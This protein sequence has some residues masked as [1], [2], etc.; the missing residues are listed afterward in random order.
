MVIEKHIDINDI[1]ASD[2]G[3]PVELYELTLEQVLSTPVQL[4][5]ATKQRIRVQD[6][7]D[8]GKFSVC[9]AYLAKQSDLNY[10]SVL[11]TSI[12]H[13]LSIF[14]HEHEDVL[15]D[16]ETLD[17]D[18][19]FN[20]Y[21]IFNKMYQSFKPNV[22]WGNTNKLIW[23]DSQTHNV[24]S[25]YASKF[26]ITCGQLATALL[27]MSFAESD[28]LPQYITSE[29]KKKVNMFNISCNICLDNLKCLKY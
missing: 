23:C 10:T 21:E 15:G 25:H 29:C 28:S 5:D 4:D 26:R 11:A 19:L 27:C 16:M 12:V 6:F 13:G 7:I 9:T 17:F 22:A 1:P 3:D 8:D 18:M 14:Q 20:N 24:V 2:V